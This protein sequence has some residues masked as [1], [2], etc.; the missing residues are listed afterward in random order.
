MM[1]A[2]FH[3]QP[4]LN[5]LFNNCIRLYWPP[6][7]KTTLKKPSLIRVKVNKFCWKCLSKSHNIKNFQAKQRCK[8]AN[9]NVCHHKL[10]HENNVT[11]PPVTTPLPPAHQAPPSD[12][13]DTLTSNRFKWSK[14]F[15]QILS[16]TITNATKIIK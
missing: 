2:F 12:P 3:F 16:L 7:E 6:P 9:C 15:L 5:R 14:T 13:N 10:L 11:R 1:S 8:V 4:T